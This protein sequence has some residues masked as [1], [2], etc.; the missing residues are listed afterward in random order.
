MIEVL[1]SVASAASFAP[2]ILSLAWWRCCCVLPVE[3]ELCEDDTTPTSWD[4]TFVNVTENA[5]VDCDDCDYWNTTTF[6]ITRNALSEEY[7][8]CEWEL[9]EYQ[10]GCGGSL[11]LSTG[12]DYPGPYFWTLNINMGFF[13]NDWFKSA[14]FPSPPDKH[15]CTTSFAM[16]YYALAAGSDCDFT[17][18]TPTVTPVGPFTND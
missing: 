12:G 6:N 5:P 11:Y 15:D 13:L 16:T 4:V 7:G 17:G 18:A 3:C 10:S 2:A 14:G 1:L 9:I 8:G